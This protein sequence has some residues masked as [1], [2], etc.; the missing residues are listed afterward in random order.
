MEE[1]DCLFCKIV[2][3]EIPS[4]IFFES[5]N[6]ISIRDIHPIS[7]G[8]SLII[9]K[10][11]YKNLL[12]FP[13]LLGN[14]LINTAKEVFFKIQKETK[15]EGFNLVQNNFAVAGQIINH[16]HFHIIPRKKNDGVHLG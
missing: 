6:F 7:E 14:E 2:R 10:K 8:H 15:C 12:D 11:H 16:L 1:K 9:S 5:E 4:E 13:N 3:K